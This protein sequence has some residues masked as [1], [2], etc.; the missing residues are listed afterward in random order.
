MAGAQ[1]LC[2]EADGYLVLSYLLAWA[3]AEGIFPL[4]LLRVGET[5]SFLK[6]S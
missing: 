6:H 4:A 1:K 5:L 3:S 2:R